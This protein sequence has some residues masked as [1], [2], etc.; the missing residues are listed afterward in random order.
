MNVRGLANAAVQRINPDV[1]ASVQVCTGYAT[2]DTGK[3]SP[4]Y[5]GAVDAM[6]QVQALTKK[7]I[8]HLDALNIAG[9]EMAIYADLQ[10][11]SIDR[12]TQTGGDVVGFGNGAGVPAQL[13]G[14]TWLVT[15]ILEGWT[16]AGWCKAGL[17]RQ[18]P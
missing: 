2:A 9:T 13:Q 18:M 11:S 7:D 5:A 10:L 14:T 15:S 3:R 6:V 8:E 12:V 1:P 4:T 16:V 17:T